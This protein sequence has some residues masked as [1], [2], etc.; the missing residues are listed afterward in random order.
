MIAPPPP[1]PAPGIVTQGDATETAGR[2]AAAVVR[3]RK[4]SLRNVLL[5]VAWLIG[6]KGV[7]AVLSLVYL[8]IVTR[9]LGVAG[10]GQ[11]SLAFGASQAVVGFAAFQSWQIVIRYGMP[12]I[13][14]GRPE[15][16]AR[17]VRFAVLLDAAS[18]LVSTILVAIVLLLLG[19]HFGWS[20]SFAR[21]AIV[22]S[23]VYVLAVH[24]T[25]VG[26]LRLHDRF[27]TGV[28][29]DTVT[30]V[31][32]F[33]GALAVWLAGPSVIAFLGVWTLAEVLTAAAHWAAVARTPGLSWQLDRPL[34]WRDLAAENPGLAIY[35]VTTN[36]SGSLE[37][38]GR[39]LAVLLVGL[40][41]T[42]AAAGGF[43][44][45][46]Q[47]AQALAKLSQLLAR[48]VFPELVRSRAGESDESAFET[49]LRRTVRMT[50]IGA[51]I[52]FVLLVLLGKPVLGLIAGHAFLSAYPVLLVLGTAAA[53]DFAAV[54]FE[55]AVIALGRPGLALKLRLIST[56]LL[57]ALMLVL[58]LRYDALGA[59]LAILAGSMLSFVL[60]WR[61]VRR[62]ARL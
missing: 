36:V 21:Q 48:A 59:A 47:L 10:F 2:E 38:G 58:P 12:H 14:G 4:A 49:L 6:G 46:Q 33:F 23:I 8:A 62:R 57:L 5:N 60:L 35:S 55:P 27:A 13:H 43:R 45:A 56:G 18:A 26:I 53:L 25:P 32:R 50:A 40:L 17:L 42:P 3:E 37:L 52:V 1:S 31:V 30:A 16:L 29:V 7:G 39:Q 34:R 9:S 41:V 22:V 11:F 54:G 19:A 51:G 24:S 20:A 15:A 61:T 28:G 44:L